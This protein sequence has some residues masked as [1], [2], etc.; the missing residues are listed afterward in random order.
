[1]AP[2]SYKTSSIEKCSTNYEESDGMY[3]SPRGV[4][5]TIR[6]IGD[7]SSPGEWLLL[8][9]FNGQVVLDGKWLN[10]SILESEAL[11][12]N[13]KEAYSQTILADIPLVFILR[14]TGGKG[15]KDLDPLLNIDNRAGATVDLFPLVLGE[16][17]IL[18]EVQLISITTGEPVGCSIEVKAVSNGISECTKVPLLI[19]MMSGHCFPATREGTVYLSAIGLDG[20]LEPLAVNFGMSLS[21]AKPKKLVWSSVSNAGF[22]ANSAYNIPDEDIYIPPNLTPKCNENC[23]SFFW[24]TI[25]R[26]LVDPV[27]LKTRLS[28][29]FVV[30]IAGVPKVGKI[31]VRGRYMAFVDAGVL[32]EPGQYSVTASAKVLFYNE[33]D[34]PERVGALLELP[35]TSAKV[36]AR[37]SDSTTDEYGHSTYLIIRF[38]L[39]ESLVPKAKMTL[40]YETMG[41]APP[42][43]LAPIDNF[44]V[45]LP[46]ED[47]AIDVRRIRKEG[48]ALAVHRELSGLACRGAVPMNQG[49][50]R[51][52]ANRLLMRVRAMLKQFPPGN[53][54]YIEWQDIVTAHHVSS[55]RAVTASFA[56]QPPILRLP[57]I[58]SAA[59]CRMAG[60][61][62]IADEHMKTNLKVGPGV[63]RALMSKA[64]RCIEQTH[65]LS[66]KNYLIKALNAHTKNRYLLWMYGG[67]EF[68]KGPEG[69]VT[70]SA[71]FRIAVKGDYSDGTT[72]AIG[73]AVLHT[74]YH[75]NE[76]FYAAFVAAKKMRKSYELVH[77]WNKF[78]DRW[79]ETSGEEECF[80]SPYVV[81]SH[82]P[83]LIAAAFFLCLRCYKF[84]ERLL[85][86][87]EKGCSTKGSR[88]Y[89]KMKITS[90]IYYLRTSSLLLRRH[91]DKA[92]EM[93]E[94]GIKN[95][96]PSGMMSQI[97]TSCLTI[98]RG[99]DGQCED[100]LNEAERAGSE[101]C[102]ALLIKAALGGL[103]T[104]PRAALQRA[105]RAH[106][107]APSGH[108]ALVI[109]RIYAK[110]G[111]ESLAERWAAVA[112]N[113]EPLLADGWAVLALLAMYERDL[114]KARTM[115]RTAR[116][117]GPV[118][119]DIEEEIKKTI[120]IVQ[121]ETLPDMLTK[122][123]CFC[124]YY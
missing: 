41:F 107:I 22:A 23:R 28:F 1:M 118:N 31:D 13:L 62:R 84:S 100:A 45:D 77:E 57:N 12:L 119:D 124:H 27:L 67:Q 37:E 79:I 74:L 24:Y 92:L 86:C 48:G 53:C 64:L 96:G 94:K 50:K 38:D 93:V 73:W 18:T 97:R 15:A 81:S 90:D 98:A 80:W 82:N 117:V 26:I 34:L 8:T 69:V 2:K 113:T 16:Q 51:T 120:E 40:L 33:S 89:I 65:E 10:G 21:L 104:E 115:L 122:N 101:P 59:R 55:R 106:K 52:A 32:L 83:I 56:P 85:Q 78:L 76:N 3:G 6:L 29:P 91:I 61:S 121:L 68:D 112:V 105:A 43:S 75:Y 46:A 39:S 88:L 108:S 30:E 95:V 9:I 103:K 42:E 102:P 99:W 58:A 35:L 5:L 70:A 63:P 109:S 44:E 110:L 17:V 4:G 7:I 116:Q 49:I 111:E 20:I 25:K 47:P 123:L 11:P 66:A 114:D 71:A 36:S 72:N 60:D 19:T 87:V 54:S 14:A